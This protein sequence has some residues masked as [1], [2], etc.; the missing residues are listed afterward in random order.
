M[1][2]LNGILLV[3]LAMAAFTVEDVFVKQLSA[4]LHVGQI[5]FGLGVGSSIIF[6]VSAKLRGQRLLDPLA[7]RTPLLMRAAAEVLAAIAFA[8]ALSLIDISVVATVFQAT[9]LVITMGAALFLGEDV[10]WRRWSAILIGFVGVLLIVRPGLS[11]FEPNTLWIIAAV[12]CVAARDLIT[13]RMDHRVD[14]T[15]VS[16]QGFFALF[17]FGPVYL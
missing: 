8:T 16:F 5:L 17:L 9:P 7:W 10:G 13:R 11:A 4:T 14:S 3:V 6:S 1:N 12:I 2:N 15:V